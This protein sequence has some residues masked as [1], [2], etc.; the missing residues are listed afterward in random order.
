[1]P[2]RALQK[3]DVAENA[4]KTPFILILKICAGTP[5]LYDNIKAVFSFMS[6]VRDVKFTHSVRDLRKTDILP[7]HIDIKT[8]VHPFKDKISPACSIYFK[9]TAVL[10]GRVLYRHTRRIEWN[11]IAHIGILKVV[12]SKILHTGR[13]LDTIG[14]CFHPERIPDFFQPVI[15]TEFPLPV[16]RKKTF[17]ALPFPLFLPESEGNIITARRTQPEAIQ[18][19][20]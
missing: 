16:Q 15:G 18:L 17:A 14:Q 11:G 19:F 7:V 6:A 9:G 13:H 10:K 8:T 20:T 5:F 1:M 2:C 3:I 4:R 12:I